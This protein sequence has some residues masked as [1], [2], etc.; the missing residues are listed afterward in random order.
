[1]HARVL[2]PATAAKLKTVT[3]CLDDIIWNQALNI[4]NTMTHLETFGADVFSCT[5][6]MVGRVGV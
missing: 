2:S 4:N 3:F 1:V 5:E 6:L